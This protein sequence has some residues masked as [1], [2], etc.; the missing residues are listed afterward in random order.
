MDQERNPTTV[1]QFL[2]HIQDLQ[3]KVNSL[4]DA[5]DFLR[6]WIREQLW[7]VPRFPV[8]PREFRVPEPCLAAIRD[9]RMIHGILRVLQETFL[10][11]SL[12]EK[13][14]PLLCSTIQRIWHRPLKN[15][16]L[17]FLEIQSNWKVKWEPQTS[18]ILVPRIQSGGGLLNHT[19]GTYSHGGMID[20]TRFPI[21]ELHLGEFP[22]SVEFQSWK[23]NVKTEVCSKTADPHLTTHWIKEVSMAK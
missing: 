11:D 1:S 22:D 19:G 9:C 12:L 23:V 3:S 21:S 13:D 17:T 18:S 20:F 14:D 8:N 10:N 16:D 6:S 7:N 5:R 2:T 4:S 15:W